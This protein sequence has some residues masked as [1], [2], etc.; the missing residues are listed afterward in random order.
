MFNNGTDYRFYD[1]NDDC[2][3]CKRKCKND[4]T[5][6]GVECG[7]HRGCVMWN[8]EKCGTLEHQSRDDPTYSTCMK[9]DEGD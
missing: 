6:A 7:L 3:S 2:D 4:D 8:S 5:C 1:A 9:Y